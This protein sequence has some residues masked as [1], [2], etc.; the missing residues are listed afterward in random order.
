MH[1]LRRTN[2]QRL[3]VSVV[4][5]RSLPAIH[6]PCSGRHIRLNDV[7]QLLGVGV[8]LRLGPRTRTSAAT[9]RAP[10]LPYPILKGTIPEIRARLIKLLIELLPTHLLR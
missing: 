2:H 1:F 5:N 9:C 10:A 7:N 3:K 6:V 8:D 4:G